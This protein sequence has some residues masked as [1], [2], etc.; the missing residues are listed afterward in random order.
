M[1]GDEAALHAVELGAQLVLAGVDDHLGLLAEDVVLHLDEA[2]EV[3]LVDVVRVDLVDLTLVVKQHFVDV[4]L[5][6]AHWR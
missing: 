1:H 2:V 5:V 4:L 3:A 6:V